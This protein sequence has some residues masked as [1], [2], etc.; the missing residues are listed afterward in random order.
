MVGFVNNFSLDWWIAFLE[1]LVNN[2]NEES[3]SRRFHLRKKR[4]LKN[5][6]IYR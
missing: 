1:D 2:D 3:K 6:K 4:K 5:L